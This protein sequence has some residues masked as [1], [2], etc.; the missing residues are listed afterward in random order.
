MISQGAD[1][2]LYNH[3]RRFYYDPLNET[4]VPIYY[5]GDSKVRD[6]KKL[7]EFIFTKNIDKRV[8]TRDITNT[9]IENSIKEIRKINLKKFEKKLNSSGIYLKKSN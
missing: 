8:L 3:N 9:N 5:D 2:S 4:F 6:L 1:H 7:N